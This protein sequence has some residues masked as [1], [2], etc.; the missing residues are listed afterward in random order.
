[1]HSGPTRCPFPLGLVRFFRNGLNLEGFQ[2]SVS[3]PATQQ[4]WHSFWPGSG[5]KHSVFIPQ[6]SPHGEIQSPCPPLRIE[7][8][9]LLRRLEGKRTRGRE[10]EARGDSGG[11]GGDEAA[12]RG[13]GLAPRG[14]GLEARIHIGE[15]FSY[16]IQELRRSFLLGKRLP[17]SRPLLLSPLRRPVCEWSSSA[18]GRRDGPRASFLVPVV[19]LSIR[20]DPPSGDPWLGLPID[21]SLLGC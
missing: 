19:A 12:A 18:C 3:N 17:L 16:H 4:N 5:K 14:G 8:Y 9:Q 20:S 10:E 21:L 13:G 11:A 7:P 6:P 15:L 2:R 1:M